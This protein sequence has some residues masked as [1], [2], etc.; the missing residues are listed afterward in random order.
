MKKLLLFVFVLLALLN[1]KIYSYD[2]TAAKYYPLAVGNSWT[3]SYYNYPQGPIYRHREKVTGTITFNNH[4]Y[5]IITTYRNGYSP[6]IHYYRV[7][8]VKNN[9][10]IY[11]NITPCPWLQNETTGDSV[12]A[13][14]GDS[15]K[16]SCSYYYRLIDT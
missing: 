9:I 4:F 2:T 1:S 6:A 3:Y 12:G 10:N 13:S 11:D 14:L 15:S 8:S 7:D 16:M 5:Y